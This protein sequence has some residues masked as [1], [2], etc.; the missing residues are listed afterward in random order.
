MINIQSPIVSR[1]QFAEI[2]GIPLSGVDRLINKGH[3]PVVRYTERKSF[4]NVALLTTQCLAEA[5]KQENL[6]NA[7]QQHKRGNKR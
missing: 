3:I 1:E 4:V 6:H 2:S 7:M 5:Q